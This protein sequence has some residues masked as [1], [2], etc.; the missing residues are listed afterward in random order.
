MM[1]NRY[2]PT[3]LHKHGF[4]QK[5]NIDNSNISEI[6]YY[7][8]LSMLEKK[9]SF[10]LVIG[11]DWCPNCIAFYP[12]LDE[13]AKEKNISVY[14]L[15]PRSGFKQKRKTDIRFCKTKDA[16]IKMQKLTSLL[17]L[18][19]PLNVNNTYKLRVPT[20]IVIKDG[21]S[22]GYWSKEYFQ[23]EINEDLKNSIKKE[24]KELE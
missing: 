6:S 22:N 19:L 23:W 3:L 18:D 15:N 14:S 13:Y 11:G 7:K 16:E 9:K 4:K 12:I 20:Y 5:Y 10:H 21:T 8:L 2:Y 24:L 17:C 1:K